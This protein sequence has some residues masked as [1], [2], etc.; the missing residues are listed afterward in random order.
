MISGISCRLPQAD[1]VEEFHQ[2]MMKGRDMVT[3]TRSSLNDS[4][5][6]RNL[7]LVA[8]FPCICDHFY[9]LQFFK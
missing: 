8:K 6:K 2:N 9:Q 7:V 5:S 1:N 3:H 4:G